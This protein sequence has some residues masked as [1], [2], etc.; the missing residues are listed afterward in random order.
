M[1]KHTHRFELLW[2]HGGLNTVS[3]FEHQPHQTTCDAKNVRTFDPGTGRARGAQRPGLSKYVASRQSNNQVQTIGHL[4]ERGAPSS[5]TALNARTISRMVVT[6]G[7]VGK[8]TTASIV[9]A[10]GGITLNTSTPVIHWAELF[11]KIYFADG[12]SAYYLWD[13][14]TNAVSAWTPTDGTL[15][16]S[17]SERARLACTWRSR[18]V[19]SG[20]KGDEHN[21]FMSRVGDPLDWEY[22]PVDGIATQAV[23]GNNADAGKSPD[24]INAL[25]PYSDDVLIFGCDSSIHMMNGDPAA[26]GEIDRITDVTGMAWGEA[27]C[28]D[29]EGTIYFFGSRGGVYRM[30]PGSRPESIS[31]DSIE[32]DLATLDLDNILVKMSWSDREKGFYLHLTALD[33]SASTHYFWDMRLQAWWPVVYADATTNPTAVWIFDGD[34]ADDRVQLLGCRDGYIRKIDLAADDDDGTAIDSYVWIGPITNRD[35]PLLRLDEMNAVIA[36]GSNDVTFAVHAGESAEDAKAAS[37]TFSG[38][39]VA[40]RN[41]SERR[42]AQ[43]HAMYVKLSNNTLDETWSFEM[44]NM[45]CKSYSGRRIRQY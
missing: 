33:G 15:P 4:M 11:G 8:F 30:T 29:P 19:L 26:G 3:S 18:I 35:R 21:W 36:T 38:D 17:G 31:L 43:G 10:S 24:I 40:G 12:G 23:A 28:K 39:W 5:Q 37:A 42:R 32:E 25:I 7:V 9:N 1:P 34:A 2:P 22:A 14:A 13:A 6:N 20:V 45:V 27:W 16:V 41:R 44:L